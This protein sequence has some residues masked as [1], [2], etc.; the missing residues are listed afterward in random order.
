MLYLRKFKYATTMT[1]KTF[2]KSDKDLTKKGNKP[3]DYLEL[4]LFF[5]KMY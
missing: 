2:M 3:K 1:V 5:Y 4:F